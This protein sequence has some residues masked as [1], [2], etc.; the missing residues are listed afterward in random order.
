MQKRGYSLI[1]L[2]PNGKT[3]YAPLLPVTG[4]DT[5]G[6]EK[7]S[8]RPFAQRP[9][10]PAEVASW[11]AECP[12]INYGIITGSGLIVLDVDDPKNVPTGEGYALPA[13]VT[14]K[15]GRGY[16]YYFQTDDQV[17]GQKLPFG[18]LIAG[19]YVVGPGSIHESGNVYSFV[20]YLSPAD[21]DLSP[22]PEWLRS[23]AELPK[24]DLSGKHKK[25]PSQNGTSGPKKHT[26]KNPSEAHKTR[27][28]TKTHTRKIY[29]SSMSFDFEGF[30]DLELLACEPVVALRVME[31]IGVRVEA[32]GKG[33]KCPLPGHDEK[34]PSAALYQ[35]DGGGVIGF[36]DF[37]KMTGSQ[38]EK[39]NAF[40]PVVE[41]YSAVKMGHYRKLGKG[42]KAIWWLRALHEAGFI[43]ELPPVERKDL[44]NNSPKPA[45]RIYE[46]FL[47]LLA[48]R[49]LYSSEQEGTPFS[50]RFAAEW[51]GNGGNI[52]GAQVG[53]NWLIDNGYIE[54]MDQGKAKMSIYRVRR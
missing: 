34:K 33:F 2:T 24:K 39:G 29:L 12:G 50:F 41:V 18:D 4:K 42:E 48:L 1:P 37:H 11:F 20:E 36:H 3:P 6:K 28:K 38:N 43:T 16:H 44:P 49:K 13:T 5:N 14:V 25:P 8:W 26:E 45:K 47:Y 17:P 32:I 31:L 19:G 10:T 21:L 22:V 53:L 9:A 51:C 40:V 7:R 54:R 52:G 27:A 30:Q 23:H 35:R 46:G 15:T